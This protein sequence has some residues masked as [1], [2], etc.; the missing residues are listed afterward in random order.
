MNDKVKKMRDGTM[1]VQRKNAMSAA[2]LAG[3][4]DKPVFLDILSQ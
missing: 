4:S 1:E 2:D 3:A